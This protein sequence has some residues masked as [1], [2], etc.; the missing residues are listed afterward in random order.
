VW[1][2]LFTIKI[3]SH[4]ELLLCLQ[5]YIVLI[6]ILLYIV[7]YIV[8]HIV[9][10]IVLYIPFKSSE[11]NLFSVLSNLKWICNFGIKS[12]VNFG[13][14]SRLLL[15]KV[16]EY[17]PVRHTISSRCRLILLKVLEYQPVRH[18]ISSR[19]RIRTQ[20]DL[21]Y[22]YRA[23]GTLLLQ[24]IIRTPKDLYYTYRAWGTLLLQEI[25]S[26]M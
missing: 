6:Y 21:Y 24:E 9:L 5:K 1:N 18:T 20:T 12:E 19:C 10:C 15:L 13:T 26:A 16:L 2:P 11:V 8:L 14:K 17:Q 4:P 25:L 3:Q 22:K 7:L 23:W